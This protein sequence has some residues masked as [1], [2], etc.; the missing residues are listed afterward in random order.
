[1]EARGETVHGAGAVNVA[2]QFIEIPNG[3]KQIASRGRSDN[4]VTSLSREIVAKFRV[5][6]ILRGSRK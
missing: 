1:V 2:G 4:V 6:E 5:N 3:G